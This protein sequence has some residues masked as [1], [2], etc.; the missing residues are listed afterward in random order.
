MYVQ[1]VMFTEAHALKNSLKMFNVT[2]EKLY[3]PQNVT[4]IDLIYI[5]RS[6]IR[7]IMW[8]SYSGRGQQK[9]QNVNIF[10]AQ[11]RISRGHGEAFLSSCTIK[12]N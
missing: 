9:C 12:S 3:G 7:Y 8:F 4:L 5:D 6:K 10:F 1:C 11:L 2:S